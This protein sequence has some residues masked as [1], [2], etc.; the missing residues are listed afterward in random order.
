MGYYETST[1]GVILRNMLENPGWYTAYTPYQAEISQVSGCAGVGVVGGMVGGTVSPPAAFGWD[2]H[3]VQ[4]A[5]W[6]ARV[7]C[8]HAR[9]VF[10]LLVALW[11][12]Q[13]TLH[14]RAAWSRC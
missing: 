2:G 5:G 14:Y 13:C 3:D 1:P 10:D 9:L 8:M 4:C 7:P 6:L 11:A 12:M